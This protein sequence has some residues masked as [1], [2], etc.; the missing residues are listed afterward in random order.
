MCSTE[1]ISFDLHG[2]KAT[3]NDDSKTLDRMRPG[4]PRSFSRMDFALSEICTLKSISSPNYNFNTSGNST[5]QQKNTD[6]FHPPNNHSD[7]QG[8]GTSAKFVFLVTEERGLLIRV[9]SDYPG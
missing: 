6:S 4:R 9:H 8:E 3:D 5:L 7:L 2:T 1:Q